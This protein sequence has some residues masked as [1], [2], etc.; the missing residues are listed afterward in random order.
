[1]GKAD[2]TA[3]NQ[4]AREGRGPA[5]TALSVFQDRCLKPLGHPSVSGLNGFAITRLRTHWQQPMTAGAGGPDAR[6][7][8]WRLNAAPPVKKR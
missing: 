6:P 3:Q 8:S 4:P 1:M 5:R 7:P 2:F